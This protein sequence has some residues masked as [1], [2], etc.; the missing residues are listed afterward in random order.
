R[1]IAS[2]NLEQATGAVIQATLGL[3]QQEEKAED[4][5]VMS[6]LA[7]E[8]RTTYRELVYGSADF[9]DYFRLA[10]PIDVIERMRMGS[11][12]ASRQSKSGIE[13][14]RA[15]PWVFAWGQSRHS[16]PGW[17]GLGSGLEKLA[18]EFGLEKLRDLNQRWRFFA[19]LLQD[20]EMAMAKSDMAIGGH[21]ANLAGSLGEHYFPVIQAEFDRTEAMICSIREQDSLLERD[22]TLRRSILLRNPYIDP[23]SF[24]QVDLLAR[25]RDGNRENGALERALITSVHGIAQGLQNTG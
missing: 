5:E 9:T 16:L 6:C 12:P 18:T 21:Y 20:A 11:R 1:A 14:L 10:T 22:P 3:D 17:Y 15:I 13:G 4:R 25:W 7:D 2:R 24:A 23:M 19:N 8:A